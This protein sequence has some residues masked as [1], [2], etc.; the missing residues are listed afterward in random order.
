MAEAKKS[1]G[2]E[3]IMPEAKILSIIRAD[4]YELKQRLQHM[5]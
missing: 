3:A 4:A 5:D 1:I 2:A